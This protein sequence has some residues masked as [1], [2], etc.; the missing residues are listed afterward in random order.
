M[1]RIATCSMRARRFASRIWARPAVKMRGPYTTKKIV[2]ISPA[3]N[4]T[5]LVAA[6]SSAFV[7]PP[8]ARRGRPGRLPPPPPGEPVGD[9]VD[10][11]LPPPAQV[12]LS[13]HVG[14][15]LEVRGPL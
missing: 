2:R 3:T 9:V 4:A 1:P 8:P 12:D 5:P 14:V 6:D 10:Q 7:P 15:L 11:F 13:Q